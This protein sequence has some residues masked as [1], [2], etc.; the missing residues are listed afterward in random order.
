MRIKQKFEGF[1]NY[2]C[3]NITRDEFEKIKKKS[4]SGNPRLLLNN[5]FSK[6]CN[7]ILEI[8]ILSYNFKKGEPESTA[9]ANVLLSISKRKILL[10]EV[11]GIKGKKKVIHAVSLELLTLLFP[12]LY[13]SGKEAVKA[14]ATKT[15]E[16]VASKKVETVAKEAKRQR[17]SE[18][19]ELG[20][21]KFKILMINFEVK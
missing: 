15:L 18:F 14:V 2:I 8:K 13:N 16:T 3:R 4:Q 11:G 17:R 21:L 10:F 6:D 19:F 5:L 12:D 1:E 9:I 7:E 20:R